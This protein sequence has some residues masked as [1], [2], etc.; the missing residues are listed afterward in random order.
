MK[1]WSLG[2]LIIFILNAAATSSLALGNTDQAVWTS[3]GSLPE[4]SQ[5]GQIRYDLQREGGEA[6]GPE[7]ITVSPDGAI[8]LLDSAQHQIHEIKGKSVVRTIHLPFEG[9]PRDLVFSDGALFVLDDS[10]HVFKV[11]ITG[12]VQREYK[13]PDGLAS[14]QVYRLISYGGRVRIWAENYH[15]FDL[16]ALPASVDLEAS[17]KATKQVGPG[18]ASPDGRRWVGEFAGLTEGVL[19]DLGSGQ[20]IRVKAYGVFGSARLVGFDQSGNLF[21]LVEDLYDEKG[22]IG[23]ETTLRKYAPDGSLVGVARLP[24]EQFAMEPKRPAEV[25]P[26][27]SVYILVPTRRSA[28]VYHVALGKTFSRKAFRPLPPAGPLSS[29][30]GG[31]SGEVGTLALSRY[32]VYDRARTMANTTWTWRNAYDWFNGEWFADKQDRQRPTDA[33]KPSQLVGLA[34]GSSTS[35]IPYYWGGFDSPWTKSDWAGSRWSSWS[36][37]LSYYI[38]KSQKGPLVG[39][40]NSACGALPHCWKDP[41]DPTK[42]TYPGG[43]GIDCSGFIA[44]ASGNSYTSKPGTGNLAGAGYD[45]KGSD[46]IAYSLWRLQPMNF[47]VNSGHTLYYY[48]RKSDLSGYDTLESTVDGAPQGS[49]FYSRTSLG[50]YTAH[51]SWWSKGTGEGPE[52]AYTSSGGG[53]ACY[54][55]NGQTRWYKFTVSGPT[56]VKLTTILGGDPDLYVYDTN[57]NLIGRST[58]GGYSDEAVSISSAG[59]YYAMVHRFSGT[60]GGCVNWIISW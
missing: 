13:L 38:N 19:K 11:S 14:H 39:D 55:V 48:K 57:F 6:R 26:D 32:Y 53:S 27:G 59:T 24:N 47:L 49:K 8:F 17:L 52:V 44:A 30:S 3:I 21:V 16:E 1:R 33:P 41:N 9:Y 58:K 2:L 29:S 50:G 7:A 45:W 34:D 20:E 10:N 46:S 37:A 23:V 28:H 5:A 4:G 56:T 42:G 60:D 43:A 12:A 25:T 35:G 22:N 15:D 51:R 40:T 18:I 31:S 36:G 54:G